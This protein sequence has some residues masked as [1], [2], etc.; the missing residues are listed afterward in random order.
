MIG[1]VTPEV[2]GGTI[3]VSRG[4]A[5]V[6]LAAT[7]GRTEFVVEENGG[8][9]IEWSDRDFIVASA[10]LILVGTRATPMRGD[11]VKVV[12]TGEVFEILAPGNEQP[13]RMAD[14]EGT[15]LRIHTKRC[16]S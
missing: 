16:P 1:R 15:L 6:S 2:A 4:N 10:D 8:Q 7:F 14:P 9:R 12:A 13:F 3:V 11:R 5:S